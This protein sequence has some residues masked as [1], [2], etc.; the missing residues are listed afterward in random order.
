M[1]QQLSIN[2]KHPPTYF[3]FSTMTLV[4]QLT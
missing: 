2:S 4:Y 1:E 3:N